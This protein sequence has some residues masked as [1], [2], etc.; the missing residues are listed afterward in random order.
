MEL[1][2]TAICAV[3][4][5]HILSLCFVGNATHIIVV[6]YV[7]FMCFWHPLWKPEG[8]SA[9]DNVW[10]AHTILPPSGTTLS[11]GIA[12]LVSTSYLAHHFDI[13]GDSCTFQA[14]FVLNY[15]SV[16]G[17]F[18]WP[19][20]GFIIFCWRPILA[21]T[22]WCSYSYFCVTF[23]VVSCFALL[24]SQGLAWWIWLYSHAFI[25]CLSV[26]VDDTWICP[27]D[28]TPLT[29]WLGL[30]LVCCFFC[31]HRVLRRHIVL[32]LSGVPWID[33]LYPSIVGLFGEGLRVEVC[34]IFLFSSLSLCCYCHQH[35]LLSATSCCFHMFL[36][37]TIAQ[38]IFGSWFPTLCQLYPAAKPGVGG[39]YMALAIIWACLRR[40]T[41]PAMTG[42]CFY[43]T[44][45][46]LLWSCE[47]GGLWLLRVG[48]LIMLGRREMLCDDVVAC[49]C[50]KRPGSFVWTRPGWVFWW[51]VVQTCWDLCIILRVNGATSVYSRQLLAFQA[52]SMYSILL[53]IL[54]CSSCGALLPCPIWYGLGY[55]LVS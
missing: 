23:C 32:L 47:G 21:G 12:L 9:T 30:L 10:G 43:S 35:P 28:V 29:Y 31:F 39:I 52:S 44:I 6:A 14:P 40:S 27:M 49:C 17:S 20:L 1:S 53:L 34:C 41:N 11:L 16:A 22:I 26:P 8:A 46:L 55:P 33:Y 7:A 54:L 2:E 4:Q 5:F 19:L 45:L 25:L 38:T 15:D 24:P 42:H 51:G 3:S 13:N 48:V 36:F 18:C 37:A 50:H